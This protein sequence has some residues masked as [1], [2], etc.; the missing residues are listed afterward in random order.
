MTRKTIVVVAT[1]FAMTAYAHAQKL[2]TEKFADGSGHVGVAA[3][4]KMADS[5]SGG[6]VLTGPGGAMVQ[7]GQFRFVYAHNYDQMTIV[8]GVNPEVARVHL[9][10]PVRA[11]IDATMVLQRQGLISRLKLKGVEPAPWI[12]AGRAALIRYS[13]VY[14]GKPVEAY[15]LFIIAQ[16]DQ[17]S[18]TYFYSAVMASPEAYAKRFPEMKAMWN[19]WSV[20]QKTLQERMD[21]AAKIIGE[22]DVPSN[23]DN[24]QQKQRL[25]ALAAARNFQKYIRDDKN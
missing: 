23:L 6:A 13:F 8:P 19:S 17:Q 7:L 5:G 15:G 10:D 11:F 12:T 3:G 4:W 16:T 22:I 24:F 1:M 18:G 25:N 2:K 21:N 20:S 9:N 14:Q